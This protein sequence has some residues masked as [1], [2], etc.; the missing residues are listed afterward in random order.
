LRFD[1]AV[2]GRSCC[3]YVCL[4]AEKRCTKRQAEELGDGLVGAR[5]APGEPS[6]RQVAPLV[7]I[8]A[9]S[10]R[11][12]AVLTARRLGVCMGQARCGRSHGQDLPLDDAA[13]VRADVCQFRHASSVLELVECLR[14]AVEESVALVVER[15]LASNADCV[16]QLRSK[17]SAR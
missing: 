15:Y 8:E 3:E 10:A 7:R 13:G 17:G 2:G 14:R 6:L 1:D 4:V 16:D 9:Q 12:V 11:H 5:L